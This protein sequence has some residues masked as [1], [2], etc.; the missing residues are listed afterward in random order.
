MKYLLKSLETIYN[1]MNSNRIPEK[2]LSIIIP[3]LNE[4]EEVKNTIESIL[5]FSDDDVEIIIINDKSD[6]SY[7]YKSDFYSYD[8]IYIE[9]KERLGVAASRNL[10]V[11]LST[12]P[13]FLLL[14]AH[15][16]F[17]KKG[18]VTRIVNTLKKNPK[19]LLCCQTK[20]LKKEDNIIIERYTQNT[21]GAV[22]NL[23][24]DHILFSQ[25]WSYPSN[26]D[27]YEE[28]NLPPI[29]C[30]L[31]ASYSCSKEYWQYLK[32]LE[33]LLHYGY[34]EPFISI[35]VWLSGGECRLLKDVVIGHIFRDAAPY[36]NDN[37][38][39]LY[40]ALLINELFTQNTPLYKMYLA[41]AKFNSLFAQAYLLIYKNRDKISDM[42]EYYTQIFVNDFSYFED[43]NSS[44]G[45][46]HNLIED[47]KCTVRNIAN[48]LLLACNSLN[49]I[50][51]M[52]GRMGVIIFLF[53][54]AEYSK[55][56]V[57]KEL[58][59]ELYDNI[60]DLLNVHLPYSFQSGFAGFGWG[61][62]YLFEN[63]FITGD[64]ND[65]LE[66]ID[67]KILEINIRKVTDLSLNTGLGG[68][69]HYI[70]SRLY[71]IEKRKLP[72]PFDKEY[73]TTLYERLK[74]IIDKGTDVNSIY[75]FIQYVLYY[76]KEIELSKPSIYDIISPL[77]PEDYDIY[78]SAIGLNGNAAVGLKLILEE[79]KVKKLIEKEKTI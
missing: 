28:N 14:D 23:Y 26:K 37:V 4:G 65:I 38:Y 40:N 45:D 78:K 50:G 64:I 1:Y 13:Y 59:E 32:G 17:Y 77:I 47:E 53:H 76:E 60:C 18:W 35:K 52:K 56:N 2:Q 51:L 66:V 22:I 3:F 19:Y 74:D 5:E 21:C 8:I 11:E 25:K 46:F 24:N 73:L 31:G 75:I 72:N 10:G 71:T 61:I 70:L 58:T 6:D 33:G 67:Q 43:I 15:M 63:D 34:D 79:G 27:I 29:P 20:V 44:T 39:V 42:K 48:M 62:E 49:D 57:F 36:Q 41:K 54:Y 68:F 7:D 9:N 30:V 12:T 69:V 55:C 16:R